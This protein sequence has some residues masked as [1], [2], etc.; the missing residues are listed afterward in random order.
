MS[1]I[2]HLL[3]S[4]TLADATCRDARERAIVTWAGVL[5][6]VDGLAVLADLASG[7]LGHGG[8]FFYP[9][10]HHMLIHGLPAALAFAAL[11][12][13]LATRR[14]RTA[15]LAFLAVHLHL[16]CDLVGS[17][18]PGA[19]DLW[20]IAY[21]EPLSSRLTVTWAGQWPL[22]AWPNLALTVLLLAL[23][24]VRAVRRGYSPLGLVSR[25]ADAA[26]VAALRGRFARSVPPCRGASAGGA[27]SSRA[28]RPSGTGPEAAGSSPGK[29]KPGI[30]P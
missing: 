2:T 15:L 21:L 1:P 8:T 25:R 19:D 11:A 6:D 26:F 3:V 27:R 29:E 14:A 16:L 18:G 7:L 22:N 5:P 28:S 12:A 13:V 20:P 17:R 9:R 10:Y 24:F 23:V 30:P 4:W